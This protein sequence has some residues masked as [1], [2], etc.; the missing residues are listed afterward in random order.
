MPRRTVCLFLMLGAFFLLAAA[1]DK[2][3]KDPIFN[4]I[5]S[6]VNSLSA[7]SGLEEEHPV[8]YGRMDK[9][10]LRQ[11][12]AKRIKKSIKPY[13]IRADELA[14]KMFGLVPRNFDLK[15]S[16]LDL[17]TEQAA[18]F[19]D[20]DTKKLY[21]LNSDPP[22]DETT[23][24]AHELAHALADQHFNLG[25]FID[26]EPSNDDED[27][28]HTSVV[29]GE[30]S[31]LMI[32]YDLKLAG[33]PPVPTPEMLKSVLDS[34][35]DSSDDYPIL[36]SSP[37][38]I[39]QSLLFPYTEGALFFNAVFKRVGKQAFTAVFT[40][41]PVDSAQ[42]MQPEKYFLHS[43]PLRPR[44]PKLDVP[45]GSKKVAGGVFG[46]FDHEMLMRQYLGE[47]EARALSPHLLGGTYVIVAAGKQRQPVLEYASAWDTPQHASR[48]FADYEEILKGK[49]TSCDPTVSSGSL[50]AGVAE[51]GFF[52]VR[53][54]ANVV[55]SVEGLPDVNEW[56][57]LKRIPI[58]DRAGRALFMAASN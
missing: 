44:L 32:A 55:T 45:G 13:E 14:L 37:L 50:F 4:Q 52:V 34:N 51:N 17:L 48:F 28:A 39:Q 22:E 9:A 40:N 5:A 26:E 58:T 54:A 30:A 53:V 38:Y 19:Y 1:R 27:L 29:E 46:E 2:T 31:W 8:R 11:F 57:R 23:T 24:L 25:R 43:A 12:L 7:I 41:P 21:L 35:E 56:Q 33:D 18:A 16:T 15:K 10:H 36:K 42:V 49:W 6:I 47:A 20:Y 3:P